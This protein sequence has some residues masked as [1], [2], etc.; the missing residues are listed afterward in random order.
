M[1]SMSETGHRTILVSGGAGF[2]GSA[3]IMHMLSAYSDIR[4]INVD[5]LTYAGNLENLQSIEQDTR[6]I[7]IHTEIQNTELM[8]SLCEQYAV[9]GIINIAAESHV[10]RSI[11]DASPFIE[12]NIQGTVSLLTV[13]RD[14]KLKKFVQVS[15]DEVYGSL[16]LNSKDLFTESTPL[17]PNSPY[18]SS[19]ASADMFVRAFHHTHGVPAV[20]TRCSNNYGPRQF[21][22]KLIPLMILNAMES[23]PL[24]VYGDGLNVRDWIHV[25]D[26]CDAI[27]RAYEYGIP[28]E[29]YNIGSENECTNLHIVKS[30]LSI[31]GISEGLIQFVKD[32]PG[33]DR[34]YAIDASK[35]KKELNWIP[36][37]SFED[38]LRDTIR[39]YQKNPEW[40]RHVLSGEYR[41]Y[42]SQQYHRER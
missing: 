27:H 25:N 13:A 18:S 34:R 39:W 21:P 19:K 30:I 32:R 23:K 20:I 2:I 5:A 28:G 35:A 22:E 8:H 4:I 1:A 36:R 15:T 14:M 40:C 26:H 12:T 29:V 24:P 37:I 7:F 3:F 33:H 17:A 16:E 10:D 9:E 42:Y 11:Q 38:G 6:H 41:D 31:L